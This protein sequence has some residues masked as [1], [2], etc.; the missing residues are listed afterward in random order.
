MTTLL[1]ATRNAHKVEEIRAMLGRIC[2]TSGRAE[3]EGLAVQH[4][5]PARAF[6]Q[7]ANARLRVVA[8]SAF[9]AGHQ[10]KLVAIQTVQLLASQCAAL[11]T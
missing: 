10:R 3:H 11:Q 8:F 6:E 7:A 5:R 9:A 1:I 4:H 2:C